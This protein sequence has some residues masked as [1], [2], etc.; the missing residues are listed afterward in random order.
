MVSNLS[1]PSSLSASSES[2]NVEDVSP[3]QQQA[4]QAQLLASPK[5]VPR[6]PLAGHGS[7]KTGQAGVGPR[8]AEGT[9][10]SL[11]QVINS[12]VSAQANK[13]APVSPQTGEWHLSLDVRKPVFGVSDQ[14][15]QKSACTVTEAG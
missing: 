15:Q 8:I 6:G 5:T 12:M 9:K 2:I 10:T 1:L 13:P 11:R 7:P 4:T 3:Q 14:V